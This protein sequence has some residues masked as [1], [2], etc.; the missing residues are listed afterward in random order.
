MPWKTL[1]QDIE[2]APVRGKDS[3]DM[4]TALGCPNAAGTHKTKL[5]VIGKSVKPRAFK[6][7]KFFHL[8]TVEIRKGR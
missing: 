7:V 2:E 5:M 4:I 3:K 1:A 8:F 6:E